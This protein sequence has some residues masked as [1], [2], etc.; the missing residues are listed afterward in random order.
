M[1]ATKEDRMLTS[2]AG[3]SVVITGASKGIGKGMAGVF[4]KNGAKV[5]MVAR[6]GEQAEAAAK[7]VGHGASGIAADVTK[8]TDL[9]AMA[10]TAAERNGGIDILCANAGIFPLTKIE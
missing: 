1:R 2:I 10:K 3:K 6:H 8:L 4:A 9:E 7:A 5:L